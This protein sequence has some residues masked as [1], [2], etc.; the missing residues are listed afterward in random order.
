V[1][2]GVVACGAL[3]LHVRRLS[4]ERG[5][6]VEIR[7]LPPQLHNRPERIAAAV[8][9]EL[10]SL[11]CD[12]LAVAYADCGTYGA[13][14]SV[15][16]QHG[17][18]R[19]RGDHC[20]DV[21]AREEVR[22]AL[23]DEPGTYFLTDFLVKTFDAS[24]ARPLRLPDLRDAYFANYTRVL[25]LAQ[26]PSAELLVHAERAAALMGLPLEIREVGTGGLERQLED[27]VGSPG[28]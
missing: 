22:E 20:Y 10:R 11:G 15:L 12:R 18:E 3:A 17:A 27:L 4:R 23:A 28:R 8:D 1:R 24:V 26:E 16:A 14:D 9:A 5:W 7:A 13:L 6:D 21:L 2:V 25:W 19:L